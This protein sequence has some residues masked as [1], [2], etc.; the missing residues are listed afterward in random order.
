MNASVK[1]KCLL[2]LKCSAKGTHVSTDNRRPKCI[3]FASGSTALECFVLEEK[4]YKVM[5]VT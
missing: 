5:L 3:L 4:K 2:P 1:R